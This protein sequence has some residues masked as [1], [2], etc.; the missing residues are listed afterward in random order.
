MQQPAATPIS[1]LSFLA[2]PLF[3]ACGEPNQIEAL[4]APQAAQGVQLYSGALSAPAS[5]DAICVATYYDASANVPWHARVPCSDGAPGQECFTFQRRELAQIGGANRS[6]ATVYAPARALDGRDWPMWECLGGDRN[7]Q[8][9]DPTHDQCGARSMCATPIES[10]AS[11]DYF[12]TPA[13]FDFGA[14]PAE[15]VRVDTPSV[16][17]LKGFVVWSSRGLAPNNSVEQ[18]INVYLP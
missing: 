10:S 5:E 18:W 16:L 3:V 13:N 6:T 14:T 17:P 7:G 15:H 9:C 11:C 4:R 2:L 8:S 1:V 12:A